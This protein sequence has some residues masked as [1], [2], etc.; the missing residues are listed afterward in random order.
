MPSKGKIDLKERML[1]KVILAVFTLV[2][3]IAALMANKI[4]F[5]L[6]AIFAMMFMTSFGALIGI[7]RIKDWMKNFDDTNWW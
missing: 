3:A 7:S 1:N 4:N 2:F 5:L 6:T